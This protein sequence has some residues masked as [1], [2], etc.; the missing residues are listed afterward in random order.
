MG[1]TWSKTMRKF[2]DINDGKEFRAA[3]TA[4]DLSM[5]ASYEH[6]KRWTFG[7]TFVY[8]TGQAATLPVQRYW[9]EQRLVSQFSERNGY[10]MVPYHRLDLAATLLNKEIKE[11]KD[12]VS[13]RGD[14]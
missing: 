3:G 6:N 13:G 5:V 7:A 10:R 11:K 1:Y 8:S 2:P 14:R 9:I 4:A 12:P